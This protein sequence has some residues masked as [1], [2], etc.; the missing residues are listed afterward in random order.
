MLLILQYSDNFSNFYH[1]RT[2]QIQKKQTLKQEGAGGLCSSEISDYFGYI[3]MDQCPQMLS[4][5]LSHDRH[6]FP[7]QQEL[8]GF[9]IQFVS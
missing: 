9:V 2:P 7:I 5:I 8:S 3:H 1:Q 6:P 4:V